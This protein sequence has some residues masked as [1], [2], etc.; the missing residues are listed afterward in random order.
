MK[1]QQKFNGLYFR[2]RYHLYILTFVFV[3]IIYYY[4]V[5]CPIGREAQ[6]EYLCR[7]EN[8]TSL[9]PILTF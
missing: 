7:K 6:F 3:Y 1:K 5:F 2:N 4:T 8:F 9:L